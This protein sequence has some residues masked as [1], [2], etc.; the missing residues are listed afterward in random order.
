M[1]RQTSPSRKAA[2]LLYAESEHGADQLYFAG[3][4]VGD[5]FI[6]FAWRGQRFGV[7]NALEFGRARKESALDRVLSLEDWTEKSKRE[8]KVGQAGPAEV[9]ATLTRAFKIPALRVAADFPLGLALKLQKLR[10]KLEPADGALFPQREI[11][12]P[13][14]ARAIAE[15]NRCS[16]VGFAAVEKLLKR[17]TIARNGQLLLDRRPLTSERLREEIEVACLRAGAVSL[18]TIAAGGDQACDPHCVGHGPLRAHELI[19]VDIFPRVIATGYHGDMTRTFLK[20]SPSDAQRKLV[21]AVRAAHGEA[22]EAVRAGIDGRTV[23]DG[24][25]EHFKKLGYETKRGA[26]GA[27]G[28]F[29][30]TGHGLGLEVHEG[31]SLGRRESK[32][33]TGAVVTVEPGLYYPGLGGCRIED[34]VQVM[35]GAPK[36]LSDYH[37]RWVIR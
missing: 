8:L 5:P 7:L 23:H 29:H 30:G 24:V 1:S 11:K 4:R 25:V 36:L 28:F 33:R 15:G 3:F 32:L 10:V 16:A 35:A 17:A 18:N 9:I 37:Y 20:G 13:A 21:A 2:T 27:I 12:S 6:T 34:V 31:P 26:K 14:E 19:I 22:I